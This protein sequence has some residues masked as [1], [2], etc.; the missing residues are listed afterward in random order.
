MPAFHR[1]LV[2]AWAAITLSAASLRAESIT[3]TAD[4]GDARPVKVDSR[5]STQGKVLTAGGDGK[6]ISHNLAAEAEFSFV[7]RRLAP[8]GRDA[9]AL[10]AAREF[11][12]ARVKTVVGDR[13]TTIELD[14]A[15]RLIVANGQSAGVISHSPEASLTRDAV[16]LLE[17]PGDP[18]AL[19]AMLPATAVEEGGTWSPPEWAGQ[20]LSAVEAIEK[21]PITC[22][23]VRTSPESATIE[24]AGTV[25]GQRQ[26]ANC[27]VSITGSM[28]FD[29]QAGIIS[30]ANLVYEVKATVGA[31]SPGIEARVNVRIQ[32]ALASGPGRL[33]D[34]M[35]DRIPVAVG[36][37]SLQLVFDAAPWG[38]RLRH[39]RDWHVFHSV[40]EGSPQVAILRLMDRGSLVA[41]CNMSPIPSAAPGQ[42]TPLE[43]FESDIAT[44]LGARLKQIAAREQVNV[45][46]N[47]KI[48]RVIAEGEYQLKGAKEEELKV[49]MHWIY[50]LCAA[51]SGQQASFVFAVESNLLEQL[52]NRDEELVR[53]LQFVA[54][55]G[56]TPRAATRTDDSQR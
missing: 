44:S 48:F 45:G 51:P 22:K 47:L 14:A 17:L 34:Q 25:K 24:L 53:N 28:E 52:G 54:E 5:V 35:L 30:A 23:L 16:D 56:P 7:E 32:R 11:S 36:P 27:E 6:T 40:L 43:R 20:M 29:R 19:A 8:G 12:T 42:H 13:T 2:L 49:P 15:T 37:Q 4:A 3:L 38:I 10:R 26:G 18:L 41:Q 39:D 9:Q 33:T 46:D 55:R 1:P 50:Y 31:V 21:A